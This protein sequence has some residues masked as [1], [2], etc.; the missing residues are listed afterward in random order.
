MISNFKYGR[1][2]MEH[3]KILNMLA[4]TLLLSA[5][6][7]A[8]QKN[9]GYFRDNKNTTTTL[10]VSPS[11][12]QTKEVGESIY[13]QGTITITTSEK[14]S[15]LGK[16]SSQLEPEFDFRLNLP[17]GS[18]GPLLTRS[19][20]G[21]P[22]LCFLVSKNYSSF[23]A[24]TSKA[25]DGGDTF[26]CLVDTDK[27][28]TFDKAMFAK[29]EKYFDLAN[30]VSYKVDSYS[31]SA[32]KK[33][34]FFIDFLYQGSAKGGLKFT[35]REFSNNIARPA[36]TQDLTYEAESDGTAIIG[37][38]NMRIKVLKATNLNITYVVEQPMIF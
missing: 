15:I 28:K 25:L 27:N 16:T 6:V 10:K 2:K 24:V 18:G 37:F 1:Q 33:S 5:C 32:E 17:E 38:K 12:P 11:T 23:A 26:A 35:Y 3:M 14:A 19:Q 30:E 9:K 36:F 13:E 7:T 8:P 21:E 34:D 4:F 31:T 29:R 20:G 22:S